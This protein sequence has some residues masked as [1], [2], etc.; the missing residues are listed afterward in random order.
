[1]AKQWDM[2]DRIDKMRGE[3][4][5]GDPKNRE[6]EKLSWREKDR[7]KDVSPHSDQAG[8]DREPKAKDRYANAQAQKALKGELED[9]FR[10]KKGDSLKKGILEAD[11]GSLQ[12]AIDA[13]IEAKGAL[14]SD[15]SEVLIKCLEA[16]RDKTL[17][18]VVAAIAEGIADYT[19][20]ARKVILLTLRTKARRSFDATLG[21]QMKALLAEHGVDD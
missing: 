7:R 18:V 8:P 17:R 4:T 14:P 1:M 2:E 15:D 9:L 19:P 16:R 21:K 13:Y 3:R 5:H 20:D 6:R 12:G 11:R 10:D